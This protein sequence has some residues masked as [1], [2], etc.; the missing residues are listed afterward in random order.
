MTSEKL[1]KGCA[2]R[3]KCV[4]GARPD[5]QESILDAMEQM[6]HFSAVNVLED[7]RR[8]IR[9]SRRVVRWNWDGK[10]WQTAQR[11]VYRKARGREGDVGADGI[12]P[13]FVLSIDVQGLQAEWMYAP[14]K[15]R[16]QLHIV[17]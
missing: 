6:E 1:C 12:E 4:Q 9:H 10:R 11:C 13:A 2:D 8:R 14:D 5:K 16:L 7:L 15:Y 3:N 17:G